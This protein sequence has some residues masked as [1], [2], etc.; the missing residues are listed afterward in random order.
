MA[1][2]PNCPPNLASGGRKLWQNVAGTYELRAD[3]LATLEDAC[4]ITDMIDELNKAWAADG[5]PMT[6]KGSTGQLII[7]P[8]IGEIRAQRMARNRLFSQLKL[9]D[10]PGAARP[11]QQRE[12]AQSRWAAAHG[13]SA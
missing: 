11:N 13:K 4:R 3:E 7:H 10:E 5:C 2:R 9:P 12:A 1:G 6:A 8:L